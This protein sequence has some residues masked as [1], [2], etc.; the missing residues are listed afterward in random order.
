MSQYNHP[1]SSSPPPLRHPVPTHPAYIPEPPP[2]PNSPQ[3]YQRYTSSPGPGGAGVPAPSQY[4]QQ[5]ANTQQQAY[6][7]A[8][9]NQHQVQAYPGLGMNTGA[10]TP[11]TGPRVQPQ[12]FTSPFQHS[13]SQQ[14][15]QGYAG[16]MSGAQPAGGA[17]GGQ[18]DFGAWGLDGATAQLGM[19][20]G[21]SAVAAGQ[22]YVQK[23]FGSMIPSHLVKHHFNVS[24]IYVM[25]KLRLVL[26]PWI[27]KPWARKHRSQHPQAHV[28]PVQSPASQSMGEWL[29]PR[30]DINS[31]DLYI[32]VMSIV[33]YVL[34]AALHAGIN[35]RF[36][37]GILGDSAS[38][39]TV[40]VVLDF[41]FVKLGCYILNITSA[42][43][44]VDILAYGG[45]KFVG[46]IFTL[47]AGFLGL[48]GPLWMLIFVYAF[49]S[50][51]FFMLRSLRPVVLPDP[52]SV[53]GV[54]GAGGDTATVS[55]AHR[56]RRI[57]FLLLE[58]GTQLLYMGW[59]VRV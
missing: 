28:V 51:A 11:G 32:P 43:Q 8:G 41:M 53:A 12:P 46:V 42:S 16:N 48:K 57:V 26:F 55:H 22:D 44:V 27:H 38:R 18:P 33:T 34:L 29:P 36:H 13:Q 9:Y 50:N 6:P 37:P 21:H 14:P 20:L 4:A 49:L 10:G 15:Q 30:D 3:G 5:P 40:V 23:N 19:Q 56:R 31:P 25:K 45:Y 47:I 35:S 58:A 52:S 2:T 17:Y 24:N 39:A 59:L 7:G 1:Q 54:Y